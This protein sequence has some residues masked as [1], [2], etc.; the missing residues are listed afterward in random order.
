LLD[1]DVTG[2]A[3]AFER[4][5]QLRP[6]QSMGQTLAILHA[7]N[8]PTPEAI[9]A[10]LREVQHYPDDGWS[11]AALERALLLQAQG[12][13]GAALTALHAAIDTGFRDVAWLKATPLFAPLRKASGW[14]ALLDRI[15]AD[16]AAQ[17]E[18]VLRAE[19][20]PEDLRPLSATRA[21]GTR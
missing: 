20:C 3:D 6:Q 1:G 4:S 21:T 19:W 2:A 10:R 14:Q 16:I 8:A 17:R 7:Q 12:D 15:E 11:D 18:Q 13:T 5:R 9:A